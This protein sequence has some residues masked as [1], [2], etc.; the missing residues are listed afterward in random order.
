LNQ[1]VQEVQQAAA[2]LRMEAA[3]TEAYN[4]LSDESKANVDN[5][6]W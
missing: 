5:L 3:F 1:E 2:A 6:V 4:A